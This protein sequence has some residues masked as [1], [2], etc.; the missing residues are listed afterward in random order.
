LDANGWSHPFITKTQGL[1]SNKVCILCGDEKSTHSE[2][3]SMSFNPIRENDTF[4]QESTC[5]ICYMKIE[6]SELVLLR[7]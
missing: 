1:L 7:C 5:G 2:K 6:D 4:P 3:Q